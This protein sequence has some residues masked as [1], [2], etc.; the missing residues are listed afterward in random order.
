MTNFS[1]SALRN[2][3][4]GLLLACVLCPAWPQAPAQTE[5]LLREGIRLHGQRDFDGAIRAYRKVLEAEPNNTIALYELSFSLSAKSDCAAAVETAQRGAALP[6]APGNQSRFWVLIGS[7]KD[8][9]GESQAAIPAF[10]KALELHPSNY[11]A[12]YNL[13]VTQGRMGQLGQA[14]ESLERAIAIEPR[15]ASSYNALSR[16]LQADG[17]NGAAML[18]LL[19][20][21]SLEPGGARAAVEQL[22]L[23][24][25]F[26]ASV[27]KDAEGKVQVVVNPK[28]AQAGSLLAVVELS[29][30]MAQAKSQADG[31]VDAGEARATKI[32]TLVK[33]IGEI[34][35][36][37][38][39]RPGDPAAQRYLQFFAGLNA[40]NLA[41]PFSYYVQLSGNG[42]VVRNWLSSHSLEVQDL[43]A[44]LRESGRAVA[45][46]PQK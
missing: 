29:M 25:L 2:L 13:A 18:A 30:G 9:L 40:R 15:H 4:A 38:A 28:T 11:L 16:V 35:E 44:W 5:T 24:Q 39:E 33:V 26:A 31:T 37:G 1:G 8:K 45:M 27:R 21:L 17:Q 32:E 42:Q 19:R 20:F 23:E 14:R 10:R 43:Q 6:D 46:P 22:R 41:K 36:K 7:C 3:G 34:G 12:H